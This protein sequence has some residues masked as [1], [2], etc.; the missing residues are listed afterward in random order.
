VVR[1]TRRACG[2]L[3]LEVNCVEKYYIVLYEELNIDDDGC[4]TVFSTGS[5]GENKLFKT[6]EEAQKAARDENS[7]QKWEDSAAYKK[8]SETETDDGML[9]V[10]VFESGEKGKNGHDFIRKILEIYEMHT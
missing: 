6:L 3:I 2:E 8:V 7:K 5:L 1:L 9:F 4:E 10:S